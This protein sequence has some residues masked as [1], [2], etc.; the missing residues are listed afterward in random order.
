MKFYMKKYYNRANYRSFIS[1]SADRNRMI[2][3]FAQ[4]SID[5]LAV[6]YTRK[7]FIYDIDDGRVLFSK[8]Q[9]NIKSLYYI[10]NKYAMVYYTVGVREDKQHKLMFVDLSDFTTREM[11]L[12]DRLV[13][14][15]YLECGLL[16]L[17]CN[18][19]STWNIDEWPFKKVKACT[20][21]TMP[22]EPLMALSNV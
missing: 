15:V 4:V 11:V 22:I 2:L 17:S 19:L 13:S 18:D 10:E 1:V 3:D 8:E 9:D 12:Q 16:V 14:A 20:N 6:I 5:K 7:F 21:N